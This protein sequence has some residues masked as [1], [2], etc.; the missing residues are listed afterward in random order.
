[1]LAARARRR[2][3]LRVRSVPRRDHDGVDSR[4]LDEREFVGCDACE[5]ER[6]RSGLGRWARASADD[7]ETRTRFYQ[8]GHEGLR[9]EAA[10]ADETDA[11][12]GLDRNGA[13][14]W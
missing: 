9:R 8:C 7:F 11:G 4:I 14:A 6:S 2:C 13:A 5:S 1:V 12:S 3:E 10:R